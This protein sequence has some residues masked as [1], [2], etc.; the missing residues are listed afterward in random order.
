MV[1]RKRAATR[2]DDSGSENDDDS[3]EPEQEA[4]SDD[5]QP[6][7]PL[8]L[9]QAKEVIT[10]QT[11]A[12][13]AHALPSSLFATQLTISGKIAQMVVQGMSFIFAGSDKEYHIHDIFKLMPSMSMLLTFRLTISEPSNVLIAVESVADVKLELITEVYDRTVNLPLKP[14]KLNRALG[15]SRRIRAKELTSQYDVY[16]YYDNSCISASCALDNFL[17]LN[18]NLVNLCLLYPLHIAKRIPPTF[19]HDMIEESRTMVCWEMAF[20]PLWTFP[21]PVSPIRMYRLIKDVEVCDVDSE[22]AIAAATTI[23]MFLRYPFMIWLKKEKIHPF[24]LQHDFAVEDIVK[25]NR[26]TLLPV[27]HAL[28]RFR[29]LFDTEAF[30]AIDIPGIGLVS[31]AVSI[32]FDAETSEISIMLLELGLHIATLFPA[33]DVAGYYE[34][35]MGTDT[36]I[37]GK[38]NAVVLA[39]LE[40]WTMRQ[41][42]DAMDMMAV[43]RDQIKLVLV[44]GNMREGTDLMY[45]MQRLVM[46]RLPSSRKSQC[47]P[48]TFTDPPVTMY[49]SELPPHT[50]IFAGVDTWDPKYVPP[51]YAVS[52]V[53]ASPEND[54]KLVEWYWHVWKRYTDGNK[55]FAVQCYVMKNGNKHEW[56]KLIYEGAATKRPSHAKLYHFWEG[57]K[58]YDNED[59]HVMIIKRILT[60]ALGAVTPSLVPS[61]GKSVSIAKGHDTWLEC[62]TYSPDHVDHTQCCGMGYAL[63][64]GCTMNAQMHQSHI[65]DASAICLNE[66]N[67][68]YN[69]V[70]ILFVD[71][72]NKVD[73]HMLRF[74]FNVLSRTR[75]FLL[76]YGVTREQLQEPYSV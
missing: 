67:L 64:L 38:N 73:R 15:I 17:S 66:S 8:I 40:T 20:K 68:P 9:D 46:Y 50:E 72:E 60:P 2:S 76:V 25:P 27:M 36:A 12:D 39:H 53:E 56:Q 22:D 4:E 23:Q 49:A 14:G 32:P 62:R 19:I 7:H 51:Q 61:P 33:K 47:P 35:F 6:S 31:S 28:V 65:N 16:R 69:L 48:W 29:R 26:F 70:S 10:V 45:E 44:H 41:L 5:E 57:G 18:S 59:R 43:H 21:G 74:V 42:S 54:A 11:P 37:E 52:Y 63:P 13:A 30:P 58:I 75:R 55:S 24:L 71:E 1:K 3:S 34:S